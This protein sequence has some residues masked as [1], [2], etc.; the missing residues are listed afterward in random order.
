MLSVIALRNL[1]GFC[2]S[3]L[4][5][6]SGGSQVGVNPRFDDSSSSLK[7]SLFGKKIRLACNETF[8][9]IKF[10]IECSS[11]LLPEELLAFL[12]RQ[13]LLTSIFLLPQI[14]TQRFQRRHNSRISILSHE[15]FQ[16]HK[17]AQPQKLSKLFKQFFNLFN[18]KSSRIFQIFYSGYNERK[19]IFIWKVLDMQFKAIFFSAA[20]RG[21]W[22]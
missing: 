5:V 13:T 10:C 15:Q 7:L 3:S 4:V 22:Y 2:L 17:T 21:I 19:S 14:A 9:S 18:S 12:N 6:L 20:V 1:L 16:S 8:L 11:L